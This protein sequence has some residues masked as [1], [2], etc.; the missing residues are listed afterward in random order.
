MLT[1]VRGVNTAAGLALLGHYPFPPLSRTPCVRFRAEL[2]AG[3]L[4]GNEQ[5]RPLHVVC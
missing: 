1:L 4:N 3:S 2:I 5:R